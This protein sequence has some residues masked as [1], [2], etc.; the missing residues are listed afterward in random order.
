MLGCRRLAGCSL[1]WRA[2]CWQWAGL[3][4]DKEFEAAGKRGFKAVELPV[5][6]KGTVTSTVRPFQS[7]NVVGMLP[8]TSHAPTHRSPNAECCVRMDQ[9][10]MYTAHYDHLGF[11]P[12]MPGDNIY[13]GAADNG[14]GV[15][16]VLK[17]ARVWSQSKLALPHSVIFAAVTA[18]EQEL[19]GSEYF[20]QHPQFARHK[21]R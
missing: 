10:V 1:K 14:T 5:R 15:A 6:L 17:S 12:G 19:L 13:N 18:E 16:M 7:P 2:S 11:V 20:G 21:L 8:G 3:D 9:A 4:L